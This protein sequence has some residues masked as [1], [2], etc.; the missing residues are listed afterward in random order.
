MAFQRLKF[1]ITSAVP[2]LLHNGQ[3]A[4]PLNHYSKSLKQI[5][6]KKDKTDADFEE[7]ARIGWYSSLYTEDGKVVL[8][9]E[10]LEASFS[11]GARK[12]KLGKQAQATLFVTKNA[13]LNFDGN[14][15][16]VDELWKRDQNRYTTWV[17]IGQQKVMRTR[18]R[19][20]EW[21][22]DVEVQYD[23]KMLN[24]SQVIDIIKATGEKV[25]LCDWRPKF[26]RFSVEFA[27]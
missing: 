24:K 10:V 19:A 25:G 7:M 2:L 5:T 23:D 14:T 4:D 15:L 6:S 21:S 26:G 12:L 9:S 16:S 17:R 22:C 20:E 8:P 1:T 3:T 11:N 18:F 13:L 27:S